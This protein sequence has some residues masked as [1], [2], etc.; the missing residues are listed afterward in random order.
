MSSLKEWRIFILTVVY[1]MYLNIFTAQ[2]GESEG[3]LSD[4]CLI[5]KAKDRLP[6][7][8]P[9]KPTHKLNVSVLTVIFWLLYLCHLVVFILSSL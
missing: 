4:V 9:F 1:N 5:L 2:K 3:S 7:Y 6:F 8:F